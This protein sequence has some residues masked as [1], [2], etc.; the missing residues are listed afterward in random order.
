MHDRLENRENPTNNKPTSFFKKMDLCMDVTGEPTVVT[1]TERLVR[2]HRRL[3]A[4]VSTV[5][6]RLAPKV[7]PV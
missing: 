3:E 1:P 2:T 5:L 4:G 7:I 6:T